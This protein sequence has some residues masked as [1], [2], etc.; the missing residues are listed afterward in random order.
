MGGDGHPCDRGHFFDSQEPHECRAYTGT[1]PSA[2]HTRTGSPCPCSAWSF[3]RRDAGCGHAAPTSCTSAAARRSTTRRHLHRRSVLAVAWAMDALMCGIG[4]GFDTLW[5][6][7]GTARAAH[8]QDRAGRLPHPGLAR[9][10]VSPSRCWSTS[11]QPRPAL[12]HLRLLGHPPGRTAHQGLRRHQLRVGMPGQ[13]PS[14]HRG[15]LRLLRALLVHRPCRRQRP[16]Q[17]DDRSSW[18]P[19]ACTTTRPTSRLAPRPTPTT[20]CAW[21]PTS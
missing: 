8:R 4:V 10:M 16:C 13:A 14:P 20:R 21:W 18:A 2:R 6:P 12:P 9:G 15:L 19:W 11:R 17:D 5:K 1:R 3:C 7:T